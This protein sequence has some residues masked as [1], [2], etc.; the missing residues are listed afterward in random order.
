ME[1]QVPYPVV[2]FLEKLP[3]LASEACSK[4]RAEISPLRFT[5]L[6][7]GHFS[8]PQCL[9][10]F[11]F[12]PWHLW[13]TIKDQC[14]KCFYTLKRSCAFFFNTLLS[15]PWHIP[16]LSSLSGPQARPILWVLLDAHVAGLATPPWGGAA[17]AGTSPAGCLSWSSE[18][19][20]DLGQSLWTDFDQL[21]WFMWQKGHCWSFNFSLEK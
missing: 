1:G 20:A 16:T 18:E 8:R 6:P 5:R 14:L 11:N 21:L 19:M 15:W 4:L 10:F 17:G 12:L 2:V 9:C 3:G 13:V 7:Q